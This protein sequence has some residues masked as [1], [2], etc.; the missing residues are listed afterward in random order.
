MPKRTHHDPTGLSPNKACTTATIAGKKAKPARTASGCAAE[1]P[2]ESSTRPLQATIDPFP[3]RLSA[4]AGGGRSYPSKPRR[5]Y[6]VDC[7]ALTVAGERYKATISEGTHVQ[8]RKPLW[9]QIECPQDST[10]GTLSDQIWLAMGRKDLWD[11]A[12]YGWVQGIVG[13]CA[14]VEHAIV[15]P[16]GKRLVVAWHPEALEPVGEGVAGGPQGEGLESRY[17][18]GLDHYQARR[19]YKRLKSE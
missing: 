8:V 6:D 9:V 19:T 11:V 18:S 5:Q 4:G 16:N 13:E 2:S 12:Q 14:V 17:Q 10:T 7:T 1:R 15:K 3:G